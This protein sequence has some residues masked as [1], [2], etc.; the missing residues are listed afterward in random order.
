MTQEIALQITRDK[1][2]LVNSNDEILGY[3]DKEE[4][5]NG[6]GV[7]HRAFSVFIFNSF[8]ELLL[9]QRSK[10]KRLWGLYW[11]NSCC[12]HPSPGEGYDQAALRRLEEEL[13]FKT[14]LTMHYKFEYQASFGEAG[15]ENEMCAVLTGTYDGA[16]SHNPDEIEAIRWISRQDLDQEIAENPDAFTPWFKMEWKELNDK[17][18]I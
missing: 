5:H 11:S 3:G 2:I 13:G 9:Q 12:S 15:S 4:C 1:L 7:L 17:K 10:Q 16:V 18:F 14:P 6:E 8:G